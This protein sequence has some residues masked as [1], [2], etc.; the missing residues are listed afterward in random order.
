MHTT[1]IFNLLT[2]F[3]TFLQRLFVI[4][5]DESMIQEP[6]LISS[7]YWWGDLLRCLNVNLLIGN[8]FFDIFLGK[9]N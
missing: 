6:I 8:T 1:I 5:V 9:V 3:T 4:N 2:F 7:K